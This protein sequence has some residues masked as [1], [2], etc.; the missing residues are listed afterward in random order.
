[1][2]YNLLPLMT[3]CMGLIHSVFIDDGV[4]GSYTLLS[5]ATE[6]MRLWLVLLADIRTLRAV[7]LFSKASVVQVVLRR[8]GLGAVLILGTARSP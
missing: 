7:P 8:G 4:Y 6:C 1:M 3:A 5:I 2:V